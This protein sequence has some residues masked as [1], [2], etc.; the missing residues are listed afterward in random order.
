MSVGP[1]I[2][3]E[4]GKAVVQQNWFKTMTFGQALILI[5]VALVAAGTFYGGRHVVDDVLP[6][7]TKSIQAGYEAL[8]KAHNDRQAA[9][10]AW[11]LDRDEKALQERKEWKATIE[12]QWGVVE[13]LMDRTAPRAKAPTAVAEPGAPGT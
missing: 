9:A 4:V 6:A 5:S 1:E 8:D 2:A 3:A 12:K 13:R 7:H 11:A 10:H